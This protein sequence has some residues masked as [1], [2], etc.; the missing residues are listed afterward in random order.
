M[1]ESACGSGAQARYD[2]GRILAYQKTNASI[3]PPHLSRPLAQPVEAH[4]RP[5]PIDI[6]F[7]RAYAV[8]QMANALA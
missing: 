4:E 3:P 2:V 7:V 6:H 8:V 1:P 5:N